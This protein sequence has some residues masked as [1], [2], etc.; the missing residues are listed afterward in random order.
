MTDRLTDLADLKR[1]IE[2]MLA[3]AAAEYQAAAAAHAM[4]RVSYF[5][6]QRTVLKAVLELF[7]S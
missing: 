2:K 7:P 3:V 6:G 1:D 4:S 5:G